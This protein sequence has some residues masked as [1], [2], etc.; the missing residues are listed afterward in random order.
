MRLGAQRRAG[1]LVTTDAQLDRI[2]AI[3]GDTVSSVVREA[4]SMKP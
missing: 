2:V 1:R 3:V 4:V